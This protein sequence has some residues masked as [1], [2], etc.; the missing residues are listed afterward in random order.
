[1]I[2]NLRKQLYQVNR[3]IEGMILS[4]AKSQKAHKRLDDAIEYREMLE[5]EL[6]NEVRKNGE[7]DAPV[8]IGIL[9]SL[10]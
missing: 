8:V 1:M 7:T 10:N 6:L 3:D 2:E 5:S 9:I 4:G